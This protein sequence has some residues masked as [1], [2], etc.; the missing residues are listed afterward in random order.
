MPVRF[1]PSNT[2]C[3][4]EDPSDDGSASALRD[5]TI[6]LQRR[7]RELMGL[8]ILALG[9]FIALGLLTFRR[10]PLDP[11]VSGA[12]WV[13]PVGEFAC[14]WVVQGFGVV[15]FLLP[16]ELTLIGLTLLRSRELGGL[17]FRLASDLILGI[18]LSAIVEVLFPDATAFA[19][20][21][22][23][24]NVGW[25]FG[26]LGRG[27]FSGL[28]TCLVA[29]TI[30][31][32]LLIGRS[33][34]SFVE[35]CERAALLISRLSTKSSWL[36]RRAYDAWKQARILRRAQLAQPALGSLPHIDSKPSDEAIIAEITEEDYDGQEPDDRASSP[37]ALSQ[38]LRSSLATT[39]ESLL[40][41]VTPAAVST[42]SDHDA[43][44][45]SASP[46]ASES[47]DAEPE[48]E[49]E[50]MPLRSVPSVSR[51]ERAVVEPRII[52]TRPGQ[53]VR[54]ADKSVPLRI[55]SFRLPSTELLAASEGTG[56]QIDEKRI[57]EHARRLEKTL[58]DYGVSAKVEEIHPGPTVTT[59]EVSAQ[60]GT[61]VSKVAGL[62]DDLALGLSRKV[63]IIAPIPGKS[64]IGFRASE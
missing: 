60:A 23:A 3:A 29:I 25:L 45:T 9:L 18:L 17:G 35:A 53:R 61:K 30:T 15:A 62:A 48:L 28:G 4:R 39:T 12:N 51:K 26:E 34:Y 22:A 6:V 42:K 37:L 36:M 58:A 59:Y 24:G 8:S 16:V 57:L 14:G 38:S 44:V 2:R 1:A 19:A 21:R 46:L 43:S 50:I 63:R 54:R 33:P 20:M 41:T 11:T 49:F 32:L 10:D 56:L 55:G 40:D 52:D 7:G 27:L 64:R 31:G 13:G 47:S 5:P